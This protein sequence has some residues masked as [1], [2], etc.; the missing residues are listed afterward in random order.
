MTGAFFIHRRHHSSLQSAT[1]NDNNDEDYGYNNDMVK[2]EKRSVYLSRKTSAQRLTKNI[3]DP[4]LLTAISEKRYAKDKR[5]AAVKDQMASILIQRDDGDV[6]DC[7]V[8]D[9]AQQ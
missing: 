2:N 3:R 4:H 8:D 1:A 7:K 9:Q 6:I 5:V